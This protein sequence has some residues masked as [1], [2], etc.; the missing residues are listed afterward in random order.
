MNYF[1]LIIKTQL[2]LV[3]ITSSFVSIRYIEKLT[4]IFYCLILTKTN[5]RKENQTNKQ[6]TPKWIKAFH[7]S[8]T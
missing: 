5:K 2:K 3:V 6:K 1:H 8:F 7:N 4:D